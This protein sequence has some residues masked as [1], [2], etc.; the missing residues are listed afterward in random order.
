MTLQLRAL[1][2]E[3]LADTQPMLIVLAGSNGAGKS[4][5]YRQALRDTG[6]PFINA[7]ELALAMRPDDPGAVAY[8]AMNLAEQRREE[9]LRQRQ[10][11]IME[12]VL[13]DPHGAKLAFL[14]RAQVAGYRTVVIFIR[15]A[16]P[17]LS[18]A[19]VMQRV[20]SGGHDVPDA[21]ILERFPRT[22]ANAR[23][24]LALADLGIVLDN[25]DLREPYKHLETWRRGRRSAP[26]R[27][28]E[29]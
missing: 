24:A 29:P 26:V 15:I 2:A 25:S 17:E 7:D 8:P 11:F 20:A 10:S 13:S 28:S 1:I 3:A 21:K 6:L 27:T 14:Q 4:T 18:R 23:K 22:L 9:A 19:R 5:Y 16:T 12:T